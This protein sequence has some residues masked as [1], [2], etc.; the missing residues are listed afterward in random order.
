[1]DA[2][3]IVVRVPYCAFSMVAAH[4]CVCA[5]PF[6]APLNAPE[7]QVW[8]MGRQASKASR[9]KCPFCAVCSFSWWFE[10]PSQ[11]LLFFATA[12]ARLAYA[13]P[14]C[15]TSVLRDA[16][17]GCAVHDSRVDLLP[18]LPRAWAFGTGLSSAWPK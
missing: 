11:F 10:D 13:H 5:S 8:A 15:R 9:R 4:R 1:M 12:G 18:H 3:T 17:P 14:R 16:R 7:R 2:A 6:Y